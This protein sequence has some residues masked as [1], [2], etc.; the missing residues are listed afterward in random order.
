MGRGDSNPPVPTVKRSGRPPS[1]VR[2]KPVR[3][4][5][6][7]R[8][9]VVE[10]GLYGRKRPTWTCKKCVAEAVTRRH[11]K[12]RR[13]LIEAAGGR[14]AVCGYKRCSFNLHFHHVDP[15]T[16]RLEMS[17][18][19]GK[20]LAAYRAEA[21]KC[22]LVCANCHGEIETGTISSPPAGARYGEEWRAVVASAPQI[23]ETEPAE[24]HADQLTLLPPD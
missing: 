4:Q 19:S 20:S 2:T 3:L 15:S 23:E 5:S 7:R 10:F 17:T 18:A 22:V 14:C 12:L 8:H 16:K 11:Q 13:I 6:C 9:G 21:R 1:V 24:P